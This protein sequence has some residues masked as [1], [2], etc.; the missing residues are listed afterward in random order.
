L[1]AD[2][3][4]KMKSHYEIPKK[5]GVGGMLVVYKTENRKVMRRTRALA[6]W[7]SLE[8]LNCLGKCDL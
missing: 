4:E 6:F 1:E 2:V 8:V 7:K 3:I 5:L